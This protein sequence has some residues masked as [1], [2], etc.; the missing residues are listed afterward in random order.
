MAKSL[1]ESIDLSQVL[2]S[3][4]VALLCVQRRPEDRPTMTSVIL[5]LGSEGV[6]TSPKEPGF[7]IG[8][9]SED[10]RHSTGTY[11]TSSTNELSI[12]ILNGR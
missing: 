3:I 4:H 9:N 5:M 2:R 11:D 1:L 8:K 6:M 7:F 10:A 12:T